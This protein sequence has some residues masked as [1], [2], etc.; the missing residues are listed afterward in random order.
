MVSSR[1]LIL[2]RFAYSSLILLFVL[3][4]GQS[5]FAGTANV[6]ENQLVSVIAGIVYDQ[7]RNPLERVDVELENAAIGGSTS[8]RTKTDGIGRY[9]FSN[10]PDGRYNVN[11]LPFRYNLKDQSGEVVV[12]TVGLLGGGSGYFSQDFYLKAKK[13]G[14][15]DTLTGVV[16]AEKNVPKEAEKLYKEAVD[17]LGNKRKEEGLIKL[18]KVIEIH[19]AYYA[20]VNR[21]GMEM[22]FTQ[23][24]LEATKLFIRA[25]QIN[26]K[27]SRGFYWMGFALNKLGNKL[28]KNYNKAALKS[29]EK[30]AT[31]ASASWRVKLLQGKIERKEGNFVAAE[32]YLLKSKKLAD[33]RNPE[34]HKELAQLYANDLKQYGKA[35]DELELY[36]KSS[37]QKD[38]NIRKQIADLRIKSKKKG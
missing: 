14:L 2:N 9:Q 19:P 36:L 28:G 35:A 4:F 3:I 13:G 33:V 15:G 7:N 34:I 20:A 38:A 11:V 6:S 8:L 21:L 16:F 23:Q 32:K 18:V 17:D 22:L 31:L 12:R 1:T 5:S 25:V 27:S 37:K 30:A 26:P 29:L 10:I 24:Y